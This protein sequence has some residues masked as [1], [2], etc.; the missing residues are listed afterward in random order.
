MAHHPSQPSQKRQAAAPADQQVRSQSQGLFS[1][2]SRLL[3]RNKL[4]GPGV[5]IVTL[6]LLSA[7]L[8]PF[9]APYQP[10]QV[11]VGNILQAPTTKHPL[12]TD[13]LGRDTLSRVIY[14]ARVSLQVG[15][16]AVGM[17]LVTGTLLGLIAGY[18]G[19]VTDATIM[20]IMDGLLAFP[21]LVLALSITVILG[22]S[23]SNVMLA[24]GITRVPD[25]ARLVR[26][27]VL[28][29]RDREYVQAAHAIGVGH[30][31]LM[32]RHI[33]PNVTAPIIV[34]ASVSIP[35]AIIAEAG[36]SFLGLGVQPPTPSWGAMISTAKGYIQQSPWMAIA[37]GTA[38]LLTVLGF[39]FLG[40]GIRDALD[41]RMSHR[42]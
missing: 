7:A 10:S 20:R 9:I 35:A 1:R 33:L 40:D 4:I 24:I 25:F 12:G 28:S 22:P 21:A 14:G 39:N 30:I 2:F 11:G 31:Q 5:F 19:G 38:I 32:M 8:A 41:P 34:L 27:Q 29:V 13:E 26:G 16:L 42:G 6:V 36:L 23:L 17:A 37:P 18:V 3:Q 15:L